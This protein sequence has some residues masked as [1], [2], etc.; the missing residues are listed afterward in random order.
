[1]EAFPD[2]IRLLILISAPTT[3]T[4][5]LICIAVIWPT[6][7]DYKTKS[8]NELY[9]TY[10]L[11]LMFFFNALYVGLFWKSALDFAF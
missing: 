7:K 6:K 9:K 3:A 4:V 8:I 11:C 5:G 2:L 10:F 1:M